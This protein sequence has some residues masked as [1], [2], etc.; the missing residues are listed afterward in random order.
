MEKIDWLDWLGAAASVAT[1]FALVIV[2]IQQIRQSRA[3]EADVRAFL[4]LS[5]Q[6]EV[7]KDKRVMV[8]LSIFNSGDVT[9]EEIMIRSENSANWFALQGAFPPE[10]ANENSKLNVR[11]REEIKFLL[12]P[13][14]SLSDYKSTGFVVEC[15]YL[16]LPRK[17]KA[18]SEKTHL[19]L[20]PQRYVLERKLH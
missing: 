8:T 14:D 5:V 7:F 19:T 13:L 4:H 20:A 15:Q 1:V 18:T 16:H 9:A 3:I 12:G 11:P 6:K 10:F 17:R 2:V